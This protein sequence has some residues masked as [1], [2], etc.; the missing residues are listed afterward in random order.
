M[1]CRVY[2]P[3]DASGTQA[4][5]FHAGSSLRTSV[6]GSHLPFPDEHLAFG[7]SK[8]AEV[9]I[10]QDPVKGPYIEAH[11]GHPASFFLGP[12]LIPPSLFVVL[13]GQRTLQYQL[14]PAYLGNAGTLDRTEAKDLPAVQRS[15]SY[16]YTPEEVLDGA[17]LLDIVRS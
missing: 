14:R 7:N 1:I 9:A 11:V 8:V 15:T 10:Q 16:M 6:Y 2:L 12:R 4:K 5:V 17:Y 13:D 3:T